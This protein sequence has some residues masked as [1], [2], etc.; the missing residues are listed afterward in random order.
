MAQVVA[1][2]IWRMLDEIAINSRKL[3]CAS[4]MSLYP[5][6]ID[7]HVSK[8]PIS[9]TYFC[10]VYSTMD[11]APCIAT[12]FQPL[13][14]PRKSQR[15]ELPIF[16]LHSTYK[17]PL[18]GKLTPST[19]ALSVNQLHLSPAPS[20]TNAQG[21]PFPPSKICFRISFLPPP[22]ATNAILT[23]CVTTGKLSV[24]LFGGGFGLSSIDATHASVSRNSLWPGNKLQVCPSGPQPSRM[25]SKIGSLTLSR[26]AKLF[27]SNCSY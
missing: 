11:S 15:K 2:R 13:C 12:Y 4:W 3:F 7:R 8:S 24:I 17:L 27:T 1:M 25:R 18:L 21:S 19:A 5:L 26:D 6:N 9:T 23:P 20:L 16:G 22:V 14:T 10:D